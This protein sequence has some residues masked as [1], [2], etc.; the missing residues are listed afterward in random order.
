MDAGLESLKS[1]GRLVVR[2]PVSQ[3][4]DAR[5]RT[6]ETAPPTASTTHAQEAIDSDRRVALSAD[7]PVFAPLPEDWTLNDG[8]EVEDESVRLDE[9]ELEREER[10]VGIIVAFF[11]SVRWKKR[12]RNKAVALAEGANHGLGAANAA[13]MLSF[14]QNLEQFDRYQR[15]KR[16]VSACNHVCAR[17]HAC[18]QMNSRTCA[19]KNS[20]TSFFSHFVQRTC[21]HAHIHAHK[22]CHR[23]PASNMD[24]N[25]GVRGPAGP[26]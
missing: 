10:A 25:T 11:R 13:G 5:Q 1:A 14:G 18:I 15:L 8:F 16:Y 21:A 7:A 23:T 6:T 12:R 17:A 22:Y 20:L 19:H 26:C 9:L 2:Q 4:S 3:V 24:R